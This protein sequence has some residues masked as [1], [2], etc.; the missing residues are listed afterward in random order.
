MR[1]LTY[2]LLIQP[3]CP[4]I[5]EYYYGRIAVEGRAMAAWP[6]ADL[7]EAGLVMPRR[8]GVTAAGAGLSHVG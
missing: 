4:F 3:T 2:L 8:L 1:R 6:G 7:A 5:T